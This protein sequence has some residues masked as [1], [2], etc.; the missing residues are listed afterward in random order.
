MSTYRRV[1]Y[2]AL[3]D[4][5]AEVLKEIGYPQHKAEI[6][7]KVLAEADARGVS[8]HGVTRLKVYRNELKSGHVR[9]EADPEIVFE[10]PISAV[11]DGHYGIGSHIS[12]FAMEICLEKT[13]KNGTCYVA[14]RN[15]NHF[16]MAG[17]WA[18]MAAKEGFVGSAFTNTIRCAVPALGRQRMLGTNPIAVAIPSDE[19]DPFLLDMATTTAARG[20]LGVY[21]RRNKKLPEGWVI[22]EEG[23][24]IT[25]AQAATDLLADPT[26]ELGGQ[27]YLGG[28]KEE[29]GGHKGYGM[30]LLVELLCAPLSMGSWTR[31]VF[32]TP[33]ANVSHFFSAFRLDLFGDAA[34]IKTYVGD[35]LRALRTSTPL[36]DE[37]R[38]Y[39]HG[40]KEAA[41][42]KMAL[43]KGV[44]LDDATLSML[45]NFAQEFG[46]SPLKEW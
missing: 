26:R 35:I 9:P 45:E 8:S 36:K 32:Q 28:S 16:G 44:E 43:E 7:A 18:E 23:M 21:K 30:G 33:D 25:G 3:V 46:L 22:D 38:V 27:V 6:T 40:Q 34:P 19:E 2:R 11:I 42:R 4:F 29:M 20:K 17:L 5:A 41:R 24:P 31:D 39:T 14:V 10:T 13:R 1:D 15:S 12:Q 37:E